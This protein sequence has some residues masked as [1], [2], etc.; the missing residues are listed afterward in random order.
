M[1]D[2]G[3]VEKY[4]FYRLRSFASAYLKNHKTG[5][6]GIRTMT[7]APSGSGGLEGEVAAAGQYAEFDHQRVIES[8]GHRG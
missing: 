4:R 7:S 6:L 5:K 1:L 2:D 3:V 8:P